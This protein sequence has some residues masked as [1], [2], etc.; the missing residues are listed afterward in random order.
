MMQMVKVALLFDEKVMLLW[1]QG[2]GYSILVMGDVVIPGTFVVL[3]PRYETVQV[4]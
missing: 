2:L 3:A 1:P 4:K